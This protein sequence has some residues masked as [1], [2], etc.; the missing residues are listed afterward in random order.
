MRQCKRSALASSQARA[1][2]RHAAFEPA[3]LLRGTL[4]RWGR[5]LDALDSLL[6]QI[7]CLES[8]L[9]GVATVEGV[10]P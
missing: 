6:T 5:V 2:A 10:I 1:A 3:C 8:A 9:E 7:A 4:K